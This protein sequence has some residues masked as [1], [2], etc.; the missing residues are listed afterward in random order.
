LHYAPPVPGTDPS[1][2][3]TDQYLGM[4][5]ADRYLI[6][7]R[8]GSG[9]MGAVYEAEHE[10][11]GRTVAVKILHRRLGDDGDLM[12][13]F[14]N[15]AR[16]VGGIRH[17]NVV[18]SYDV[19]VTPDGLPFLVLEYIDGHSLSREIRESGP[20]SPE[21]AVRVLSQVAAALHAA[22]ERGIVHRD[23]KPGNV[24]LLEGD[25]VKVLDFGISKFGAKDV[26]DTSQGQ[27]IGSPHYMAPEQVVNVANVD[28]RADIYALGAVLYEMLSGV[29]PFEG[30]SFPA[31]LQHVVREEPR[32]LEDLVPSMDP[33]IAAVVRRAMSKKPEDRFSTA[34][35]LAME[36]MS[37]V[38]SVSGVVMSPYASAASASSAGALWG[39]TPIPGVSTTA[40]GRHGP[41][42]FSPTPPP[43]TPPSAWS[44][45]HVPLIVGVLLALVALMGWKLYRAPETALPPGARGAATEPTE[46]RE[47]G[48]RP[49]RA[50]K[51]ANGEAA[52][53]D[54]PSGQG[55]IRPST[56]ARK[57][58]A[59]SA[60]PRPSKGATPSGTP[61]PATALPMREDPPF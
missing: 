34:P 20:M 37:C 49:S 48:E 10:I 44:E 33:S 60:T 17:P 57:R 45:W 2:R 39:P 25:V 5:L 16:A 18:E 19:A 46:N 29:P 52:P 53:A 7:R 1:A 40:S 12:K 47:A 30:M 43:T 54:V 61:P 31:I 9:A 3:I 55:E 21:R 32:A 24:M 28:R 11:L 22:H 8:I 14:M 13:R 6:K 15:E 59:A 56:A 38:S 50:A 51:S 27:I 41:V 4:T 23:V 26:F 42:L 58:S 35:E 36:L